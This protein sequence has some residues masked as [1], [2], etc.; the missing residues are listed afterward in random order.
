MLLRLSLLI[1][2]IATLGCKTQKEVLRDTVMEEKPL[3]SDVSPDDMVFSLAKGACYGSC[4]IYTL[5]IYNNLYAEFTGTKNTNKLGVHGK[6]LSQNEIDLLVKK[7]DE[8][9]F[10]S[11]EEFYPS[12]IPDLPSATLSYRKGELKKSVKGKSERPE[13]LH[14]LQFELERIAESREG[15]TLIKSID[16]IQGDVKIDHAKVVVEI[17]YGNRL[18]KWFSDM[19]KDHGVQ[20]LESLSGDNQN[21]LISYNTK[22]YTPERFMEILEADPMVKSASFYELEDEKNDASKN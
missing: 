15:W 5:R 2:L 3:D 16:D 8:A 11:F 6:M 21:W 9:S 14:K 10:F 20:I 22:E 19:R 13:I 4:P 18:A 12:D 1:A 7:F 17:N